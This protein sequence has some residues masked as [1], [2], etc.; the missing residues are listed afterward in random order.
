MYKT[1]IALAF[2]VL[3]QLFAASP[4]FSATAGSRE[5]LSQAQ[6]SVDKN[7]QKSPDNK[8][9]QNAAG[10]LQA[11]QERIESKRTGQKKAKRRAKK[12]VKIRKAPKQPEVAQE[13]E[14]S[15]P[16]EGM[17]RTERSESPGKAARPSR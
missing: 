2:G 12:V 11:N 14:R 4:G 8:G 7:L 15:E 17:E 3:L 9:L 5:P 6:E 10:R 16:P 13:R 1:R